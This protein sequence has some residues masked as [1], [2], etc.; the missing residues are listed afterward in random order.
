MPQDLEALVFV[1]S[2]YSPTAVSS[3][4][5]RRPLA[6]HARHRARLRPRRRRGLRRAAQHREGDR[7]RRPATY[8]T[9]T[10]ASARGSS[11]WPPTTWATGGS[12]SACS[13]LSTNDYWT[14]VDRSRRDSPTRRSPT[15]P[16]ILAVALLLRNLD[17][18]GFDDVHVRSA[19]HHRR[20]RRPRAGRRCRIVARAAGTSVERLHH[21][22]PRASQRH[23]PRSGRDFSLHIPSR[24]LARAQT[25]LPRLLDSRHARRP[26][27]PRGPSTSTGAKTSCRRARSAERDYRDSDAAGHNMLYRVGDQESLADIARSFGTSE[28]DIVEDNCLDPAAKLQSGMLLKP[29]ARRRHGAPV[30]QASGRPHDPHYAAPSTAMRAPAPAGWDDPPPAPAAPSPSARPLRPCPPAMR[31]TARPRYVQARRNAPVVMG[32]SRTPSRGTAAPRPVSP[33]KDRRD[34]T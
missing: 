3:E 22:Q 31:R 17:R 2:G 14:L 18:F 30:A 1:E 25:M 21:A 8:P 34:R 9:S 29:R 11:R 33:D 4:G 19:G 26:R 27:A 5:R 24:G 7:G 16:K 12:R 20:S 23:V 15:C 6:V 28:D 13:D 10:S 32:M